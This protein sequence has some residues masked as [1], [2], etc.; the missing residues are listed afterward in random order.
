LFTKNF[1][2]DQTK[3]AQKRGT[4]ESS[5]DEDAN[6]PAGSSKLSAAGGAK[7]TSI[8]SFSI[9][10]SSMTGNGIVRHQK[11][12]V[13][14]QELEKNLKARLAKNFTSVRKAF[15]ALDECNTGFLTA[16]QLATFLDQSKEGNIDFT[17]ME[18]LVKMRMQSLGNK[19]NYSAFSAWVGKDI[20][21]TE[22]F[23]FRHDSKKNP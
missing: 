21:P 17:L 11:I 13:K 1:F 12:A 3:G 5:S 19:I 7:T 2:P 22:N 15:L 10:G 18:I 23:Y 9:G 14:V 4:S 16:E 20:E 6:L 8:D